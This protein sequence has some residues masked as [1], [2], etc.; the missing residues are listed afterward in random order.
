[1]A[2]IQKKRR[3][4]ALRHITECDAYIAHT[5]SGNQETLRYASYHVVEQQDLKAKLQKIVS[6]LEVDDVM[7]DVLDV[8]PLHKSIRGRLSGSI[9]S[10]R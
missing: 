1:M 4:S 9:S 3:D 10:M 6:G 5:Q 7:L 8:A 2:K